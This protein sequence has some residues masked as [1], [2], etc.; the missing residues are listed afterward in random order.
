MTKDLCS[1]VSIGLFIT[2]VFHIGALVGV[3]S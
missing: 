2:L 3:A 1:L